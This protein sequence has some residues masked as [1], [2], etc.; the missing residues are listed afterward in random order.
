M[1][2]EA[3][4]DPRLIGKLCKLDMDGCTK[5]YDILVKSSKLDMDGDKKRSASNR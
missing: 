2:M 3:K 1:W 4:G 5:N